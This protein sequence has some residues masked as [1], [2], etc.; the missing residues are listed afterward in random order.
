[1]SQTFEDVIRQERRNGGAVFVN[2]PK[3]WKGDVWTRDT[4][5]KTQS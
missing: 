4:F 3:N 1:M 5:T 2:G